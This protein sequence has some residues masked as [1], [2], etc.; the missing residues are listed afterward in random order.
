MSATANATTA[1]TTTSSSSS[2]TPSMVHLCLVGAGRMGRLRAPHFQNDSRIKLIAV[3]DSWKDGGERLANQY[4]HATYFP[5]LQDAIT[6]DPNINAVWISTPTD[7]HAEIITI[8]V[9]NNL[10]IFTEK[11]VAEDPKEIVKLF[12]IAREGNVKLCCGF[13]RR[14]D[15]SY[16]A[17]A[18]D[19]QSGTIGKPTM[20]T[21]FFGDHPVPPM[22]FLKN[23]GCPFMDLSP[24]DVDY[25]R[26][27]LGQ[28]PIEIFASGSSSTSELLEANVLDNAFVFIKFDGGTIVTLQ[29][30][31]GA[32]YGYDQR[33]EFFGNKGAARVGN[34]HKTS[35]GRS[36]NT[37][38]H[39]SVLKHSFPERFH[40]A[41]GAEVAAFAEVV[42]DNA[43]WPVTEKDC[44]IV[45]SI[46]KYAAE[47]Q[48]KGCVIKFDMPNQ[49]ELNVP[50]IPNISIRPIGAGTFGTFI[51]NLIS[52]NIPSNI[53]SIMPSFTRSSDL[54]W[55]EDVI[56][57]TKIDAV[58]VASPDAYHQEH[59]EACLLAGKHVLVEKP[60]TPEFN[61]LLNILKSNNYTN[62]FMVGF[63]RRFANEF[64]NAKNDC[65]NKLP[66]RIM[67][68]SFDP[69]DA[70]SDLPFVV[71]NSMCHDVDML[72]W[73]LPCDDTTTLIWKDSSTII[74]FSKSSIKLIGEMNI[75]G[76]SIYVELIYTK[77]YQ[78]YVQRV[79]IDGKCYGYNF[80]PKNGESECVI[81]NDA[82]TKQFQYFLQLIY[83]KKHIQIAGKNMNYESDLNEMKRL[84][85]Y[86]RSFQWLKDAHSVLF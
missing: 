6:N 11:P 65:Y 55:R 29:M 59:A 42:L 45:Q 32:T 69:V 21:V 78:S 43:T 50:L 77:C 82:Y 40:Q 25:V 28:E 57:D 61:V 76:K 84:K 13:Q 1:T 39:T 17:C 79:T 56:D 74:D 8:A 67:I 26:N 51:R 62:A 23:G 20:A 66:A 86:R 73:I 60:V 83:K 9:K 30:S 72:S 52:L 16:M 75:G 5:T 24:H 27:T 36:D 71:N 31:R 68:E 3:V 81:Y 33:C 49:Y 70:C 44:V 41:F 4:P 54:D 35:N 12:Q 48:K 18:N 38:Y 58:Y 64:L 2:T 34:Q 85:S 63:Q 46:A 14:F 10:P 15:T 37:G 80:T 53:L 19:V 47:S 7:Q 22:E